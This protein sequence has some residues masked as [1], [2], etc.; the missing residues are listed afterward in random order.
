MG[1]Q[2][3]GT[4]LSCSL[5]FGVEKYSCLLAEAETSPLSAPAS[6]SAG[7]QTDRQLSSA[8]QQIRSEASALGPSLQANG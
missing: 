4:K 6:Q 2:W 5:S 7:G 8:A 3:E 1:E